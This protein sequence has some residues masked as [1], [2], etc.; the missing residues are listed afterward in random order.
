MSTPVSIIKSDGST[1]L[2]DQAKLENSLKRAGTSP[3]VVDDITDE[4]ENGLENGMSTTDIYSK[5]FSLLRKYHRPTAVKYSI[6]RALF[7]LG[8][9]GFPFEKFV[10]RIFELWG[11]EAVTDQIVQGVC[12]PHEIDVVAWKGDEL[13]MAEAKFHN[14]LGLKSDLKV[15]LYVKARFDDIAE[16]VFDYGKKERKISTEGHYLITNTKF[17][18]MAVKYA[19]CNNIRLIS[20][21]YPEHDNLHEIIERN[22]LHPIT[23]LTTLTHQE[24]RDIIGRGIMTCIDLIGKPSMLHEVG[25]KEEGVERILTEAQAVVQQAK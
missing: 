13:I 6:R 23:V 11:Y 7:D 17:T 8:P 20:W 14:V 21:N 12:V 3:E 4:I 9:D 5:A 22:G 16:T 2:F 18:D 25:I 1:E 19:T 15:A 10:A 24:K